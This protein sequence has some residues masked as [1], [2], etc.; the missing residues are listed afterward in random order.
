MRRETITFDLAHR[1]QRE[2]ESLLSGLEFEVDSLTVLELA[3]D[4]D[5][6]AYDCAF[7]ALAKKLDIQ[8]MTLDGKLLRAFPYSKSLV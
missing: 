5:C 7:V 1:L 4:S 3:R 8:L 6:S 2:A